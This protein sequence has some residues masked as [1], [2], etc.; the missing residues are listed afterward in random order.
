MRLCVFSIK[1]EPKKY[2]IAE[3]KVSEHVEIYYQ[4]QSD[5]TLLD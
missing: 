5:I 1:I 4:L 3:I 2:I